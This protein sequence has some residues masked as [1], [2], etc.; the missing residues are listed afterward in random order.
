MRK[1]SKQRMLNPREV[2]IKDR[3]LAWIK[4]ELLIYHHLRKNKIKN[5]IYQ[6]L[7][8]N[9]RRICTV[10]GN[11]SML[12]II[13]IQLIILFRGGQK[14]LI[15]RTMIV[16]MNGNLFRSI[17]EIST[18]HTRKTTNM[19][20]MKLET[21]MDSCFK[22]QVSTSQLPKSKV[23][24]RNQLKP[25]RLTNIR[26]KSI[27]QHQIKRNWTRIKKEN[28]KELESMM[29]FI[30]IDFLRRNKWTKSK[31]TKSKK[32]KSKRKKKRE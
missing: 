23:R 18:I 7:N 31:W 17:I 25:I 19:K 30:T 9:V 1:K 16:M 11:C 27:H 5:V 22:T 24:V 2:Q 28:R 29:K 26:I 14:S 12:W 21:G 8:K 20:E 3:K 4:T 6:N 32:R 15:M 10:T 13:L